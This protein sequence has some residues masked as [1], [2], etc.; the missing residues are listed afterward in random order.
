MTSYETEVLEGLSTSI[1]D[2]RL[3]DMSL[4]KIFFQLLRSGFSLFFIGELVSAIS[5]VEIFAADTEPIV[6]ESLYVI[7]MSSCAYLLY[8]AMPL[9]FDFYI[10][11][12]IIFKL[13]I[14]YYKINLKN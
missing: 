13:I 5:D 2:Y 9:L 14:N 10:S 7:F 12:F 3:C 1:L 11:L 4:Y 8:P 6:Q